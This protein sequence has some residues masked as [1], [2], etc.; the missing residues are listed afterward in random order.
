MCFH[1][2]EL[3]MD[4]TGTI[5]I[6]ISVLGFRDH[7]HVDVHVDVRADVCVN[8]FVYVCVHV[9]VHVRVQG[10]P[11]THSTDTIVD[12]CTTESTLLSTGPMVCTREHN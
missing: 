1:V 9:R 5:Q 2:L 4:N 11:T 3:I 6:S 7:G 8:V 10:L 12:I